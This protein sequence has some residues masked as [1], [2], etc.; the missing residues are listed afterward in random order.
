MVAMSKTDLTFYRAFEDTFRGSREL[1]LSRLRQ[2]EPFFKPFDQLG[3]AEK[4][5]LDLGCGRGEWL[6][7]LEAAGFVAHG[8]DLDD[9]MLQACRERGFSI[10]NSD[11]I[12]SLQA[13]LDDSLGIVSAFHVVEHIPFDRLQTLVSESLRVLQPGGLLILETPN[14]ENLVIGACNFYLDPTHQRPIPPAL[15]AFLPQHA[16]FAR[17]RVV[18]LQEAPELKTTQDLQLLQVI[19]GASPDYAVV[20]QKQAAPNILAVFDQA[21]Q[22]DFGLTLSDLA[23]RYENALRKRQEQIATALDHTRAEWLERESILRNDTQASLQATQV[24]LLA[25]QSHSVQEQTE[26]RHQLERTEDHFKQQL[27]AL[28][29]QQQTLQGELG[30]LR[31]TESAERRADIAQLRDALQTARAEWL[32]RESILRGLNASSTDALRAEFQRQFQQ[33]QMEQNQ[34]Q[35]ARFESAREAFDHMAEL[36][37]KFTE[38]QIRETRLQENLARQAAHLQAIRKHIRWVQSTWW[39]RLFMLFQRSTSLPAI[40]SLAQLSNDFAATKTTPQSVPSLPA[41]TAQAPPPPHTATISNVSRDGAPCNTSPNYWTTNSKTKNMAVEHIT[42]LF[43]LDG[44]AFVTEAYRNL[45][46][47]EPDEHGMAYYLGRLS[48]GY[49]KLGVI[50]QLAQSHECRPHDEIKGLKKLLTEE[51]HAS[52]WFFRA[53]ARRSRLERTLQSG[54]NNLTPIDQHLESINSALRTQALQLGELSQRLVQLQG[55]VLA[56]MQYSSQDR[57]MPLE[58]PQTTPELHAELPDWLSRDAL[59][60]V[61]ELIVTGKFKN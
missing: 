39:W 55:V 16:G 7:V 49:G 33:L 60:K 56:G 43:A 57:S 52:H 42:E 26:L 27:T 2:Y 61:K 46:N 45:L 6:E 31:L 18:R 35:Q 21:F 22:T 34:E 59:V 28:D 20:A 48:M 50:V 19:E 23:Q 1:I 10:E 3:L 36:T 32:E 47:R 37:A 24:A 54:L 58:T 40:S 44:R 51:H 53:F 9:G 15:L 12:V 38:L 41:E 11:G 17:T 25:L 29:A 5:A 8:V 4:K 13:Q 14:P 30:Q